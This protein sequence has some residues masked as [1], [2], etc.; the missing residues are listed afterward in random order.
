MIT[1]WPRPNS[2][3]A[4]AELFELLRVGSDLIIQSCK[5]QPVLILRVGVVNRSAGLLQLRLAEFHDRTQS[6]LVA[7]L[8]QLQTQIRFLQQLRRDA[9]SLIRGVRLQPRGAYVAHDLI[10]QIP[11]ALR[12]RARP[13]GCLLRF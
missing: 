13:I 9:D 7:G 6:E 12:I 10:A 2:G 11:G 8:R 1:K 5:T 4:I 3:A